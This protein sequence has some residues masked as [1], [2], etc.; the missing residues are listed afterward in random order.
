MKPFKIVLPLLMLAVSC[1]AQNAQHESLLIGPGDTLQV[2]VLEA[3]ELSQT[4]R[5][6]DQGTIP[7]ILGGAVKVAGLI[8]SQAAQ[9]IEKQL[10]EKKYLLHPHASVAIEHFATQDVSVLGQVNKP[11]AI[12]ILTPRSIVDVLAMAGGLSAAADRN[13]TIERR[14][15][16]QEIKYFVSNDPATALKDSIQV[17]P[18]D[19][20]LVPKAAVVYVLGDV[21]RP[22]GFAADT[23]DS[24]ISVLQAVALAGG[25]HNS[26][27]PSHAKLIR[28]K[29][30]GSYEEMPLPLSAMQ[31]GKTADMILRAD[32][33]VYVPFSYFR[34]VAVGMGG[35]ISAATS[36]SIYRY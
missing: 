25:T 15:T 4:V 18:G 9:A 10:V 23:N 31:K 12:A 22:G 26:A 17:Y 35:L 2:Q 14:G 13:I 19:S 5:V 36:A 1:S 16:K 6:T 30:D 20:I 3:P 34:N 24:T 28:K 8:P 11:G 7:L 29:A 27:V 21:G 33:I 32:D